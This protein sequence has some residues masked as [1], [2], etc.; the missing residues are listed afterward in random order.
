MRPSN[1]ITVGLAAAIAVATGG[2]ISQHDQ[3]VVQGE[4]LAATSYHLATQKG[5]LQAL[6]ERFQARTEQSSAATT[7]QHGAQRVS[8]AQLPAVVVAAP[9]AR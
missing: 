4:V 3:L 6:T 5:Q 9:R 8:Q 1:L 7:T 2:S